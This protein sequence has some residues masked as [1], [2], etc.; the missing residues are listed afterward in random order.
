[1]CAVLSSALVRNNY[2]QELL[3][4]HLTSLSVQSDCTATITSRG[5]VRIRVGSGARPRI[6]PELDSI[7]LS[8]FGHRFMSLA[9]QMGRWVGGPRN[10]P[11]VGIVCVC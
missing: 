11:R 9:E 8:I 5:D 2:A 3:S 1:M 4:P 7:Q 6:G 10:M